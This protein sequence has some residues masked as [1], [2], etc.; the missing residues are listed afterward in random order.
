ME[1]TQVEKWKDME[2]MEER[3]AEYL[4]DNSKLWKDMENVGEK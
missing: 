4:K 1:E 3:Q 2:I